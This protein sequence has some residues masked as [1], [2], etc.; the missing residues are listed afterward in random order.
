MTYSSKSRNPT[1]RAGSATQ[2]YVRSNS[3]TEHIRSVKHDYAMG[4]LSP[5]AHSGIRELTRK[6]AT[7][8]DRIVPQTQTRSACAFITLAL[9]IT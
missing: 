5:A 9:A 8:F 3:P 6:D 2:R 4:M 7:H 1:C